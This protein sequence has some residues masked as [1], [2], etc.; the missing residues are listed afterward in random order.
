MATFTNDPMDVDIDVTDSPVARNPSSRSPSR[1]RSPLFKT[2]V[3]DDNETSFWTGRVPPTPITRM[4]NTK[5]RRIDD[6]FDIPE[7]EFISIHDIEQASKYKYL[8]NDTEKKGP[9]KEVTYIV[10]IES[11]EFSEKTNILKEKITYSDREVT[12]HSVGKVL[13]D[14]SAKMEDLFKA[15]DVGAIG[16]NYKLTLAA[17]IGATCKVNMYFMCLNKV[18]IDN[19]V[20]HV[21]D[22]LNNTASS[23]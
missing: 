8:H 2:F 15:P 6:T 3:D 16:V 1:S 22:I 18:P 21:R 23:C 5:R 13:K 17:F 7:N 20:G 11:I 4:R 19:A 9:K 12:G 14:I 10:K